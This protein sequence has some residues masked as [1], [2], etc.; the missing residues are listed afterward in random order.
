MHLPAFLAQV[1]SGE[2]AVGAAAGDLAVGISKIDGF[3]ASFFIEISESLSQWYRAS[4]PAQRE[5]LWGSII[6]A[7][8]S[9]LT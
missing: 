1:V 6:S 5:E 2:I 7:S 9:S 4:R 8:C 3:H